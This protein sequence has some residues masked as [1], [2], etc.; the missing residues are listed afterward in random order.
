MLFDDYATE[1]FHDEMFNG[2]G[3]PRPYARLLLERIAT[4][5]IAPR[6]VRVPVELR[7]RESTAAAGMST[8]RSGRRRAPR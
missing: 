1:G 7:I 8:R 4:P 5:H 3:T 6:H 2:D